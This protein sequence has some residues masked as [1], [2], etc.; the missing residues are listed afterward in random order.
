MKVKHDH[1]KEYCE[2]LLDLGCGNLTNGEYW[3]SFE[4]DADIKGDDD[5]D[6]DDDDEDAGPE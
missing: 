6:G 1:R 3:S 2:N 5:D 4:S